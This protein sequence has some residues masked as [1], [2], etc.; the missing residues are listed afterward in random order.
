VRT[1]QERVSLATR[2]VD[3][4]T[5]SVASM[6]EN[7]RM[8]TSQQRRNESLLAGVVRSLAEMPVSERQ[9]EEARCAACCC[10]RVRAHALFL[11]VR[12]RRG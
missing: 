8:K 9:L 11:S 1:N 7:V 4:S 10:A 12:R 5:E 3:C 2:A 6:A